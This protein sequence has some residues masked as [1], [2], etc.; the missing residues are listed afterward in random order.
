[1][2]NRAKA[3]VPKYIA[4]KIEKDITNI[5]H[6]GLKG[7]EAFFG[8]PQYREESHAFAQEIHAHPELI[9]LIEEL[10]FET[11]RVVAKAVVTWHG[12]LISKFGEEIKDDPSVARAALGP[13]HIL[14]MPT[15]TVER[16]INRDGDTDTYIEIDYSPLRTWYALFPELGPKAR[17][18]MLRNGVMQEAKPGDDKY[19]I[20]NIPET[21]LSDIN[22]VR[23]IIGA[24]PFIYMALSD[25]M[26]K[27][28][29]IL[30]NVLD[31]RYSN[32]AGEVLQSLSEEEKM[33]V[34]SKYRVGWYT[35]GHLEGMGFAF[36]KK[37]YLMAILENNPF[38]STVLQAI[39]VEL[40]KDPEVAA[41][42]LE[43]FDAG[44]T[45]NVKE[46]YDA[47]PKEVFSK[48]ENVL[49]F[50]E[51]TRYGYSRSE[52][53]KE[54]INNLPKEEFDKAARI[55]P[56]ILSRT[57]REDRYD[58]VG[59]LIAN[60]DEQSLRKLVSSIGGIK[61]LP[62]QLQK[63]VFIRDPI[64]YYGD[65]KNN[66]REFFVEAA[67]QNPD[68]IDCI[69]DSELRRDVLVEYTT[70]KYLEKKAMR[71]TSEEELDELIE[72]VKGAKKA[73]TKTKKPANNETKKKTPPKK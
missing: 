36:K 35:T 18:E 44:Y 57:D 1:M 19:F 43:K 73:S 27:D 49:R 31:T 5:K 6:V 25:E 23:S 34:I 20:D 4:K 3:D 12:D 10:P 47:F 62:Q 54:M 45:S 21:I 22:I 67:L 46:F 9:S 2:F 53:I 70:I 69:R 24:R 63:E 17:E 72:K 8:D 30:I 7:A 11:R 32:A 55:N 58:V 42:C 16:V 29:E 41:K 51:G 71:I 60:S 15:K 38:N 13:D 64:A 40:L 50:I 33:A 14:K 48:A 65:I 37:E 68:V 52:E 66:G 26:K 56:S 59:E 61:S 28:P 39:D